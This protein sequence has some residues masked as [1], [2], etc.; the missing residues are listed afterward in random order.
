M[1]YA[2]RCLPRQPA[3]LVEK[4]QSVASPEEL[5]KAE[6]E[7][8]RAALRLALAR[9]MKQDLLDA[10]DESAGRAGGETAGAFR[11]QQVVE[12]D[13]KLQRVEELR[14]KSQEREQKVHARLV[15][16]PAGTEDVR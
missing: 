10:P 8:R 2:S 5:K 15:R 9:R 1:P 11:A 3:Q 13:E 4:I 6:V 16:G 12:L 14:R 7:E